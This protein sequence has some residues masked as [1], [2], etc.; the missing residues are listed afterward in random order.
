[1]FDKIILIWNVPTE[2]GGVFDTRADITIGWFSHG[3]PYYVG[4]KCHV[5]SNIDVMSGPDFIMNALSKNGW[6]PK[7]Y[8]HVLWNEAFMPLTHANGE[9][10]QINVNFYENIWGEF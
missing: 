1:M 2:G 3:G 9:L 6:R 7:S 4:F 5:E 10:M 8:Q